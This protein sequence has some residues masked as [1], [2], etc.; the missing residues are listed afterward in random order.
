MILNTSKNNKLPIPTFK[1][2][3]DPNKNK[4]IIKK[5]HVCECCEKTKDYLYVAGI[6]AEE[7]ILEICP[8]C[9][10]DGSA[11]S[12]WGGTFQDVYD[13]PAG[14]PQSIVEEVIT[15]TPGYLSWQGNRWLFSKTDAL[16]FHGTVIGSELLKEG[17]SNKIQTI[18][19]VLNNFC[20]HWKMA[21]I[22]K[23]DIDEVPSVYLFQDMETNEYRAYADLA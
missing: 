23:L 16:L 1:Y 10:K 9:I 13:V 5:T 3:P 21:D 15:R 18:L 22:K 12:K 2:Y 14:V 20:G 11:A 4:S 7:E 6:Y 17:D 8:W 19:D